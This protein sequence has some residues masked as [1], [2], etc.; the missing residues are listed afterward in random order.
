MGASI[1]DMNEI[2]KDLSNICLQEKVCAGK[3]CLIGYSKYCVA[4]CNQ[5]DLSYVEN[6]MKEIPLTDM[7]GGYDDTEVLHAIAHLLAQC[8]SCKNDHN[9]NCI[10]NIVRS[11]YEVIAF[12]EEQEYGGNPLAHLMKLSQLNPEK[13]A[14]VLEEYNRIKDKNG[15]K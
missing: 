10:L 3:E 6:G 8:H 4:Q 5:K 11:A 15:A 7:R 2:S 1:F 9:D 12:G 14:I 13:G